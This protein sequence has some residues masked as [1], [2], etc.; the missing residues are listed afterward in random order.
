MTTT[1]S[2][3]QARIRHTIRKLINR[4]APKGVILSLW[5]MNSQMRQPF[6]RL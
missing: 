6:D 4:R 5:S 1:L 3:E 2:K